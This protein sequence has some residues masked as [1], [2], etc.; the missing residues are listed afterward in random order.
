MVKTQRREARILAV[1]A[2]FQLDAQGEGFLEQVAGFL[3]ETGRGQDVIDHADGLARG[4]WGVR[5]RI[6]ELIGQASEHWAVDRITPVDRSVLRLAVYEMMAPGGP[7]PAVAIDEAIELAKQ[8]GEA[9]SPQF[10]NG[11]L[12][13]VRRW[14]ADAGEPTND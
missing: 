11:V 9:D 10:V 13:A 12:D 6:D 1:Q 3:G 4:A 7:P 2:L 14:L 8:F 5:A